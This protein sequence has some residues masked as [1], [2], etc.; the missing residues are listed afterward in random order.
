MHLGRSHAPGSVIPSDPPENAV[1]NTDEDP[2]RNTI[3]QFIATYNSGI[4]DH[5]L[6]QSDDDLYTAETWWSQ[7]WVNPNSSNYI[8][9]GSIPLHENEV[10]VGQGENLQAAIDGAPD[11][12]TFRLE[13][14][15]TAFGRVVLTARSGIHIVS[16]DPLNRATIRGFEAYAHSRAFYYLW[17]DGWMAAIIGTLR[18]GVFDKPTNDLTAVAAYLDPP[19]DHILRSLDITGDPEGWTDQCDYTRPELPTE[20]PHHDRPT[21]N[22]IYLQGTRDFLMEDCIVS[23]FNHSDNDCAFP[24]TVPL[25]FHAGMIYSSGGTENIIARNNIIDST[26]VGAGVIGWPYGVYFDGPQS[27]VLYNNTFPG[28]FAQ[29]NVLTLTN[30]DVLND[31]NTNGI[32]DFREFRQPRFMVVVGNTFTGSRLMWSSRNTRKALFAENTWNFTGLRHCFAEMEVEIAATTGNV[33]RDNDCVG[34]DVGDSSGSGFVHLKLAGS[35]LT[36]D[37]TIT[38]NTVSGAVP[39]GYLTA[40]EDSGGLPPAENYTISG[41]TP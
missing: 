32:E 28:G 23:G 36:D 38:G 10:F 20:G 9:V 39:N 25:T 41:N 17:T 5:M 3:Q 14:G 1:Y 27:C 11:N 18:N 8:P 16:D 13:G 6:V 30:W 24:G 12:T 21:N 29:G 35:N 4:P 33:I 22:P 7:H 37:L 19:R 26:P 40:E 15:A 31:W 2:V 34:D